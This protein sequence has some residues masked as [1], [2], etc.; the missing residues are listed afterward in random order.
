MANWGIPGLAETLNAD[1]DQHD[2]QSDNRWAPD[3]QTVPV[4]RRANTWTADSWD[5][6]QTAQQD[7]TELRADIAA[8][9]QA[10]AAAEMRAAAAEE[11]RARSSARKAFP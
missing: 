3:N 9:K 6:N 8:E 1:H 4:F 10:R 2:Q 7:D 5:D 11:A